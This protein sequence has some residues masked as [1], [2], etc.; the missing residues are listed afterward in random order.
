MKTESL[1][2]TWLRRVGCGAEAPVTVPYSTL[3]VGRSTC[4]RTFT[5]GTD[6]TRLFLRFDGITY[7]AEVTLNGRHLGEMLPY[8]EYEF[9]ITSLVT[10]GENLLEVE[11]EDLNLSFGPTPGWE[12]FGGII[13]DVSLIYR[14]DNY[15]TDVFFQSELKNNYRDAAIKVDVQTDKPRGELTVELFSP[16][17]TPALTYAQKAGE[18]EEKELSGIALWSP[19]T[20]TLYTLR[21]TLADGASA[22]TYEC[23]VGF[24]EFKCARHKFLLNGKP[25][26]IKGLCKHEMIGDSGHV[27]S[28][29]QIEEDM[30][31]I[32]ST[33][34]N[35]VRLVHYPHCKET[36][37]IADRLGL[38]VSEEPGLWWSDTADEAVAGGSLEVLRRTILRDR[39]H[40]SIVFW[41]SFNECIFTEKF[42][43][44]S[45]NLCR[46]VDPTRL[47]SG[48]NCMS[49]EDT[50]IYYNKCGFDFYTMHPYSPTI[51]RAVRSAQMLNDK[52][53]LFTEWGG[54]HVFD[55]PAYLRASIRKMAELYHADSD[56]GAL[57]GAL[58][59][60]WAD[61][62]DF[63]RGRPCVDG[64][65]P[66][67]IVTKD[68]QKHI[69]YDAFCEEIAKI[70]DT[71]PGSLYE[72]HRLESFTGKPL[73][74]VTTGGSMDDLMA[75]VADEERA[76]PFHSRHRQRK[77]KTPPVL[78]REEIAGLSLT[79]TVLTDGMTLT[80]KGDYLTD[81]ITLI[82]AVSFH[83]GYPISGAF[84]ET[85]A[86]VTVVYE[87]GAQ[88][89]SIRNGR[90]LTTV[91]A[92]LASSRIDPR[93]DMAPR[94]AEF[95]YDK[96]FELYVINRLTL[97]LNGEKKVQRVEITSA[98]H[99]Y[100]MLTYGC[101]AK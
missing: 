49:D 69:C 50:L 19:D 58:L 95:S 74:P 65:L 25:L 42:L 89:F 56:E 4:R 90:E 23:H 77:L 54:Y 43:V 100:T 35:F 61:M 46:E 21:V 82:G 2:G 44:D 73:T 39:N 48:A 78:E 96:N 14:D 45:A 22:D 34:S 38:M 37:D 84:E 18:T 47:V 41:L 29:E 52:P 28:P 24:R 99:G 67:G 97:P 87:G 66:E 16:D 32:K 64:V 36:V 8:C 91:F 68:R 27:V 33:G 26:F 30:R 93:A 98:D 6:F 81:S 76:L 57:A 55:N 31:M 15:I 70:E 1:N 72:F 11:L 40:P 63:N 92:S 101:F 20:P 79:P 12:N 80:Y 75:T 51:D 17:G 86:T 71:L 13:R 5:P 3:P 94:F 53:L 9:E 85:A 59:W 62:N 60:C 7:H 88:R 83:K 10:A